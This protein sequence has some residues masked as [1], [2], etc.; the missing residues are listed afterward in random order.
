MIHGRYGR[1]ILGTSSH[2]DVIFVE[3][4]PPDDS[5]EENANNEIIVNKTLISPTH[6]VDL[7]GDDKYLMIEISDES[8]H[9]TMTEHNGM[10]TADTK[11]G[12]SLTVPLFVDKQEDTEEYNAPITSDIAT[13]SNSSLKVLSFTER[14]ALMDQDVTDKFKIDVPIKLFDNAKSNGIQKSQQLSQESIELSD[15]EINYSMNFGNKSLIGTESSSPT[16]TTDNEL[17]NYTKE[18]D[19]NFDYGCNAMNGDENDLEFINQSICEMFEK[20]FDYHD[21]N[22]ERNQDRDKSIRP[23]HNTKIWKKTQS[24]RV[25]GTK[26]THSLV[27]FNRNNSKLNI[28][29]SIDLSTEDYIIRYGALSPRPD[30]DGMEMNDLQQELK[31]FG[32]KQSLKKRQAII[33]LEY[34]FNRTHPFIESDASNVAAKTKKANNENAI[35]SEV[36]EAKLNF[37]IG[38]SL[39]HLVDAKFQQT[40]VERFFLPSWPRAKRPWCLQP[41]HIA[42][43]NLVKANENLFQAILAYKPIEL[44]DLKNYFKTIDM[45]FDNKD[46]IAFLDMHCITFRT[47]KRNN[48]S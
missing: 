25:L 27:S 5:N 29:T 7:S 33:C 8:N 42:W 6:S 47:S 36:H 4:S 37:N 3:N 46:L 38:F 11:C 31:K 14:L 40:Q 22:D 20:T 21:A 16:T 23:K 15:D 24:E 35:S 28:N 9:S 39:D 30:Y 18:G 43:H 2:N 44:R 41:L 17:Q 19:I 13:E 26:I 45:T 10:L 12:K 48:N 32:L 34:I 1:F